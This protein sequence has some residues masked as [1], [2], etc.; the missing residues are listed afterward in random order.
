[1]PIK[2]KYSTTSTFSCRQSPARIVG[3][4]AFVFI[5]LLGP[6]LAASAP[7]KLEGGEFHFFPNP[8]QAYDFNMAGL[9]GKTVQ[10]ADLKGKVVLLNFWRKDCLY[11]AQEKQ[12]LKEMMK[13]M[14]NDKLM[15]VCVNLWDNP[16]WVKSFGQ[17]SGQE[18]TIV[19]KPEG[20]DAVVENKING[21]IMGYFVLNDS[22][23]AIYEIKGFPST[24]VIDRGGRVVASHLGMAKWTSPSIQN[25]L[26]ELAGPRSVEV[27]KREQTADLKAPMLLSREQPRTNT[28]PDWLDKIL[29]SVDHK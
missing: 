21:K 18:L 6:G 29:T 26:S 9:D 25:W 8:P 13:N 24:Y 7:A 14:R 16:S 22:K 10:L 23:E 11:C 27:A 17:K 2:S 20:K 3:L 5:T 1:M 12:Y 15:V 28:L 4:I 19:S